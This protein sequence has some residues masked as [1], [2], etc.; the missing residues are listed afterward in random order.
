MEG[1][2]VG[3][4]PAGKDDCGVACTLCY[5]RHDKFFLLRI[6]PHITACFCVHERL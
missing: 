3:G 4:E 5:E 1:L 2:L 6:S